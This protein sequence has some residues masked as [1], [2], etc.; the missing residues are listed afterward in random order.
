MTTPRKINSAALSPDGK[1]AVTAGGPKTGNC[2][3]SLWELATGREVRRMEGHQQEIEA[4]AFSPTGKC[5]ACGS[6]DGTVRIWGLS[7]GK[8]LRCFRISGVVSNTAQC[9][10]FSPDGY[11]VAAGIFASGHDRTIWMWDI[12][13][14]SRIELSKSFFD[15]QSEMLP[16]VHAMTFLPD[17]GRI[18]AA[19]DEFCTV[20]L[21]NVDTQEFTVTFT[22]GFLSSTTHSRPMSGI[23]CSMDGS[24]I[25]SVGMDNTFR[26]WD[27]DSFNQIQCFDTNDAQVSVAFSPDGRL[28]VTGGDQ[29]AVRLW[30]LPRQK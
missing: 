19:T 11:V 14:G 12:Q 28:A 1:L 29:G 3:V 2:A 20:R 23:A 10:A 4:V 7:T 8:E 22:T 25:G 13:D 30:A 5:V 6:Q 21:W 26:L 18:V 17:G 16:G 24:R 27:A 15:V 9:V